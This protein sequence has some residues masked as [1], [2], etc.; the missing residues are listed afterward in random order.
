MW[1]RHPHGQ[2]VHKTADKT[3]LIRRRVEIEKKRSPATKVW[4]AQEVLINI[5]I[6]SRWCFQIFFIFTLKIGEMIHFD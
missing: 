3:A 4:V 5:V 2:A 1:K 6:R